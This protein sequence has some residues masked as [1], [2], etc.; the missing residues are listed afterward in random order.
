MPPKIRRVKFREGVIDMESAP[1][2]QHEPEESLPVSISSTVTDSPRT[3]VNRR[4]HPWRSGLKTAGIALLLLT[5]A[6]AAAGVHLLGKFTG[7][8]PLAMLG[9]LRQT[10]DVIQEPRKFFP[11][12][13]KITV[14]CLGLDRN[15][16]ISKDPKLNGMPYTK[17]ARS[18]VMMV[19]TLDLVNK[20]VS[21]L[22]VPR[23][24]RIDY[25]RRGLGKINDAHAR[26]GIPFT[27]ETVER[28]LE[29]PVNHHVVIK[30]EAIEAVVDALGG[31]KLNVEHDMDYDDNWGQLHIH[32]KAGE[33][34]LN[35]KEVVGFM[36][37]RH[38]A[39]GDFGRIRRQ[40]QVI[41]ALSEQ[42]KNPMV[43]AKAG[44]LI[45]AIRK[46]VQTD[47]TPD[48]QLALTH[49]FH[50]VEMGNVQTA[51]LPVAET[52][53]IDGI[54]YVI[55]DEEKKKAVVDWMVNGNKDAMNRLIRVELKNASGD[56]ELY[57]KV[58]D[59]LR[60]YGFD[61]RRA[62]RTGGDPA[63]SSRVVQCTNLRGAGRRVLDVL[64]VS[65]NVEKSK[66]SGPDV[67][68]YVGKDL[69]RSL[70]LAYPDSWPEIPS[71]RS[72]QGR[73]LDENAR[74]ERSDG[75][76]L[77]DVRVKAVEEP[78]AADVVQEP[79]S[80]PGAAEPEPATVDSD[81]KSVQ[82]APDVRITPGRADN[83]D[84]AGS[85]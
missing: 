55:P 51:S 15:I 26:G 21:I 7:R 34:V 58:Y 66:E 50:K 11:G 33:R 30:Q 83:G 20:S 75:L 76:E 68:L 57:Q 29:T 12:R 41:Q 64:G 59:C 17:D 62:G 61:V 43:L 16:M 46:Y 8:S 53:T 4:Q 73:R 81:P 39:E 52:T 27:R 13:D 6:G 1:E 23:D 49:L 84:S 54:S 60:H 45:D 69:T 25:K 77:I 72:R 9:N 5:T 10:V 38:D 19:A 65:G 36:R 85:L 74:S 80:V 35:G 22:S 48:Q 24:T 79:M 78:S 44:G 37:F 70:A 2:T 82:S 71:R 47:L 14:L 67:T 28:F 3:S 63:A 18:D 40:Q 31:L 32:L 42:V 56:R